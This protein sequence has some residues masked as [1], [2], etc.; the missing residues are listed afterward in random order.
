MWVHTESLGPLFDLGRW[1]ELLERA[2][3]VIA[4]DRAHGGRYVSV[5]A[6]ASKGQVLVWRGRLAEAEAVALDEFRARRR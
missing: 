3:E 6:E 1:D 4:R 5:M 2:D